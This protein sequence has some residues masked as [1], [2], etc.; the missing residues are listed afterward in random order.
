MTVD[1]KRPVL[2]LVCGMIGA[3]KTTLAKQIEQDTGA[4]RF[5]PDEWLLALMQDVHDRGEMDRLRPAVEALQWSVARSLLGAGVDVVLENGFWIRQERLDY[6]S[7][8][9]ALGAEVRLYFLDLPRDELLR[10]VAVRNE[11]TDARSLKITAAEIDHWSNRFERPEGEEID[12]Y[13]RV[14]V[15]RE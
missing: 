6:C 1:R 15:R 11:V 10:R 9:K 12:G 4:I 14:E 3:G 13:D 8:G 7:Q 5:C 2:H